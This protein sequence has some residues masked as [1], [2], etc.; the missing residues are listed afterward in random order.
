MQTAQHQP[1]HFH[2]F[3]I[4]G[5]TNTKTD[6]QGWRVVGL[7]GDEDKSE[8]NRIGPTFHE[9]DLDSCEQLVDELERKYGLPVPIETIISHFG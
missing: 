5:V 3:I 9:D 2:S 7:W 6:Q 1:T 8:G 4:K